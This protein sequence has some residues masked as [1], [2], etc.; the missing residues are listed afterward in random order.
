MPVLSEVFEEVPPEGADMSTV[1]EEAQPAD[2]HATVPQDECD[3]VMKGGIT[4]GVVYPKAA[5]SSRRVQIRQRRWGLG[6][7]DRRR[8][9]RCRRVASPDRRE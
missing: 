5:F 8:G 4:S 3:I 2:P 7:S 9:H 6:G 1:Q